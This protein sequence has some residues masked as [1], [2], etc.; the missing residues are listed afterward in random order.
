MNIEPGPFLGT[1]L[2]KVRDAQDAGLI[3]NKEEALTFAL[4]II[5]RNKEILQNK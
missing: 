3:K 1:I 4:E 2:N 5:N